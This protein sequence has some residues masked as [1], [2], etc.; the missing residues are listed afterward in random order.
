[1][2]V[3]VRSITSAELD[4]WVAAIHLAFHV[5]RSVSVADEAAFRRDVFQ[6]DLGR[7]LAAI[8]GDT[9]TIQATDVF[10]GEVGET[11]QVTA[12][13]TSFP[14]LVQSVQFVVGQDYLVSATDG[15][16]SMCGLSGPATGELRSLYD[17]A[18]VR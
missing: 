15:M 14:A 16:V 5:D 11:V 9:V 4:G 13:Q 3:E 2:T 18:F 8:D 1:M 6:Q 10:T 17:K 12:L 7:T